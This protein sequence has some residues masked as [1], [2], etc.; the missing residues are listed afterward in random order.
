MCVFLGH[1]DTIRLVNGQGDSLNA[2]YKIPL[3]HANGC[4]IWHFE[5]LNIDAFD[6]VPRI[7]F[8]RVMFGWTMSINKM[9]PWNAVVLAKASICFKARS[10]RFCLQP[11]ACD[12]E[13]L[14]I[15]STALS[16]PYTDH[17]TGRL[18]LG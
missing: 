12:R 14:H 4:R 10:E 15:Y 17:L 8:I 18:V 3:S 11:L 13:N 1:F 9:D 16:A 5:L 6:R 2:I 7:H